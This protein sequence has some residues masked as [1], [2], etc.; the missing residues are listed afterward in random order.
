MDTRDAIL[1][2]ARTL[3]AEGDGTFS[4]RAVA[5][6]VG[7][8]PM[9][10]YR[11]FADKEALQQALLESGHSHLLMALQAGILAETPRA[12]LAT[13]LSAYAR[14]AQEDPGT[15][16]LLFEQHFQRPATS[17]QADRRSSATFRLLTDR[18]RECCASHDL[19]SADPEQLALDLWALLH[20][21]ILLHRAGKTGMDDEALHTH[22]AG[23]LD[24][25]FPPGY[26]V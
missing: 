5:R 1:A 12:R 17:K 24:R 14:F 26:T 9:A 8:S 4:L 18:V 11:H 25:L 21:H 13:T 6:K 15:Y 16:R 23:L 7:L 20:G 2:A 22:L 10:I 3:Q 19:P